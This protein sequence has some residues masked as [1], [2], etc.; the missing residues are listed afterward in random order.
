[1][2]FAKEHIELFSTVPLQSLFPAGMFDPEQNPGTSNAWRAITLLESLIKESTAQNALMARYALLQ[3]FPRIVPDPDATTEHFHNLDDLPA[4]YVRQYAGAL[5][6]AWFDQVLASL[7]EVESEVFLK[8][9]LSGHELWGHPEGLVILVRAMMEQCTQTAVRV[10]AEPLTG[11]VRP[12]PDQLLSRLG[13][14][15]RY[16]ALGRDFVLGRQFRSRPLHYHV[17]VGPITLRSLEKLQQKGWADDI[18]ASQKFHRLVELVTPFYFQATIHILLETVGYVLGVA[19]IGR[20]RLG[21]VAND[22]EEAVETLLGEPA[23]Q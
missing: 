15:D 10:T 13:A 21:L 18:R 2:S 3:S 12:V 20:D 1:M 22:R 9:F 11:D 7:D 6:P 23:L 14:H 8:A 4:D 17:T 19:T 16:S 5:F